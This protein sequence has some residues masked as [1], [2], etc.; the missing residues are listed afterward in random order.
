ML[1]VSSPSHAVVDSR[2]ASGSSG[3][4]RE[5]RRVDRRAVGGLAREAAE[6][7]RQRERHAHVGAD[8]L[9]RGRARGSPAIRLARLDP[10]VVER[11]EVEL[12]RLGLDDARRGRRH[13]E[14][15]RPRP[16]GGPRRR[17]TRAPT[18][19]SVVPD[20]RQR[21]GRGRST[22]APRR[23]RPRTAAP[24]RSAPASRSRARAASRAGRSL[25]RAGSWRRARRASPRC[26]RSRGRDG[27]CGRSSSRRR[28]RGRRSRGTPRRAG[29][30]PSRWRR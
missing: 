30:S 3:T 17:A 15:A 1:S 27:R 28:R 6:R 11:R 13:V 19:S 9:A 16:A 7:R 29:R 14:A 25:A 24:G 22:R 21:V 18:P 26:A 2:D 23:G 20:E 5:R 4:R 8:R 10:L 12:D